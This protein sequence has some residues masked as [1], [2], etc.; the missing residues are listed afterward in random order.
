MID[1]LPQPKVLYQSYSG[2]G[3]NEYFFPL[4]Q[5]TVEQ[6]RERYKSCEIVLISLVH[7]LDSDGMT[8]GWL[9]RAYQ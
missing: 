7:L 5:F 1:Q 6:I 9:V 8:A 4:N 2:I 3:A